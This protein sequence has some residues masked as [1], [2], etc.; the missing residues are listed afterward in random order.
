METKQINPKS[1][2][3]MIAGWR[4]ATAQKDDIA[5]HPGLPHETEV[6]KCKSG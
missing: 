1:L 4:P 3:P 5:F 2:K 6:Q